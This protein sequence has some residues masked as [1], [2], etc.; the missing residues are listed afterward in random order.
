MAIHGS[1]GAIGLQKLWLF[2]ANHR[3]SGVLF[4]ITDEEIQFLTDVNAPEFLETLCR[5]NLLH[6]NPDNCLE[7]TNWGQHQSWVIGAPKRS[8]KAKK[9]AEAR[10]G[11]KVES[12]GE[13]NDKKQ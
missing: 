3:Q 10:W 1:D 9:A 2:A 11:K 4:D 7:I 12:W 5:L 8:E 13:N 6:R